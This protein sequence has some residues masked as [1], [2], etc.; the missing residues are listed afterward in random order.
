MRVSIKLGCNFDPQLVCEAASLNESHADARIDEFFGSTRQDAWLTARP[1][2]RLPEIT[3]SSLA[4]YIARCRDAGIMFNYTL[5]A[6]YLG[7]KRS[8]AANVDR[9][10][11]T[12]DELLRLGVHTLT[13]TNPLM[14]E[15]IR[16]VSDNARLEVSTIAHTDTVTQIKYWH[17]YY[18]VKAIC[19][20]ILKNRNVRFL[21]RAA[22]YCGKNGISYNVI[23]NEFCGLGGEGPYG[24]HCIFRDSCYQC[25]SENLTSA[26]DDI[27]G[28]YPM[29]QCIE[30]RRL[31]ATWLRTMFVRPEDIGRYYALG[32]KTFKITGRTGSTRNLTMVADAYMKRRWNGNLLLLWKHL[33]TIKNGYHADDFRPD[34]YV[35]NPRLDGFI[36][37][38]FDAP[39]RDCAN[40]I[41]GDT[42]R[43][44]DQFAADHGVYHS[45]DASDIPISCRTET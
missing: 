30:A 19:G 14:A 34:V 12:V 22:D 31:P 4:E 13:I 15:V 37:K 39:E 24:T 3:R 9:L 40:E 1:A 5:N 29:R 10:K 42:C 27:L 16:Q 38:W 6:P 2:Y 32:I 20:N 43:Y 8:V 45:D 33:E 17:E 44:C 11:C 23:V 25:H 28:G 26:D 18:G 35:S 41:C 7:S 21:E 36:D